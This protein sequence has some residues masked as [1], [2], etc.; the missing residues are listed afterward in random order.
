MSQN[1]KAEHL[2]HK[3]LLACL[4]STLVVPKDQLMTEV[5]PDSE[6]E[7]FGKTESAVARGP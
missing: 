3:R 7:K 4:S 1:S 6:K 2:C 5:S